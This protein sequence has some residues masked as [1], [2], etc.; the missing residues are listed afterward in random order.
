M[1]GAAQLQEIEDR[2]DVG[3]EPVVPLT[4]EGA[5][6]VLELRDR[7]R[8]VD[9]E[10]VLVG[11]A[12]PGGLVA[13][14]VAVVLRRRD[15]LVVGWDD[16]ASERCGDIR[17][18]VDLRDAVALDQV[19]I[20]I[21]HAA[22]H[23]E[24]RLQDGVAIPVLRVESELVGVGRAALLDVVP[25]R[26]ADLVEDVVVEVVL[27]GPDAR[28]LVRVDRECGRQVLDAAF[29]RDERVDVGGIRRIV[30][31]DERSIHVAGCSRACGA[32]Q[33]GG[34]GGQPQRAS[35]VFEHV[36]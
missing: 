33:Q 11:Y 15:P 32:Q 22:D 3:I 20:P 7:L 31:G 19:L 24:V 12:V 36:N 29:V 2:Q 30:Q 1:P 35:D 8:R 13:V 21:A 34:R 17:A 10:I 14:V 25:G 9:V 18:I 27:V 6:V 5:V 16:A 26:H 28:F 23:A 4:G